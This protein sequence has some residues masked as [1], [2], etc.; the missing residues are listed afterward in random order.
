MTCFQGCVGV[1]SFWTYISTGDSCTVIYLYLFNMDQWNAISELLS[2]SSVTL[3][4]GLQVYPGTACTFHQNVMAVNIKD[5]RCC[6]W[7]GPDMTTAVVTPNIDSLLSSQM[8]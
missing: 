8:D 5:K 4:H 2:L 3:W 1:V 7:G 6:N